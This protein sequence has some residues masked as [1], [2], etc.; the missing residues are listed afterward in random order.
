MLPL[1]DFGGFLAF[2]ARLEAVVFLETINSSSS[3]VLRRL[4]RR[5]GATNN[6]SSE[7]SAFRFAIVPLLA[8][9]KGWGLGV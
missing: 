5:F 9:R 3:D 6:P 7:L 1:L 8:Q 4:D 2:W